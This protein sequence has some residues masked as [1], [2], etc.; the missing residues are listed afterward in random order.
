MDQPTRQ[1]RGDHSLNTAR[2]CL[3]QVD[4]FRGL[5]GVAT[6]NGN[7]FRTQLA[8]DTS[9]LNGID[10]VCELSVTGGDTIYV[11]VAQDSGVSLNV[12]AGTAAE[13]FVICEVIEGA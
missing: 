3:I 7:A 9:F 6:E 1:A 5:N 2:P 4:S 13:T 10:T 8:A 12:G 11:A